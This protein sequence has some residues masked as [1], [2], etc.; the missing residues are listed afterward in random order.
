MVLV[1]MILCAAAGALVASRLGRRRVAGPAGGLT[2]ADRALRPIT[3]RSPA[4]VSPDF[5]RTIYLFFPLNLLAVVIP[6]RLGVRV[7]HPLVGAMVCPYIWTAQTLVWIGLLSLWLT[8]RVAA[9]AWNVVGLPVIG[10]A[11]YRRQQKKALKRGTTGQQIAATIA[12]ADPG[13]G[14]RAIAGQAVLALPAAPADQAAPPDDVNPF[15]D[16]ELYSAPDGT[17]TLLTNLPDGRQL[18]TPQMRPPTPPQRRDSPE[19]REP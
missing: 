14:P 1:L 12:Q 16:G 17:V 8:S 11:R 9:G 2:F 18:L 19:G 5:C 10:C 3:V 7:M 4:A 13:A 15:G 6:K